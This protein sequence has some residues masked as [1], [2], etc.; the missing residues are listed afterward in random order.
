MPRLRTITLSDPKTRLFWGY[1]EQTQ[2]EYPPPCSLLSFRKSF[3]RRFIV[4]PYVGSLL[5]TGYG[6]YRLKA[7]PSVVLVEKG[8]KTF[9]KS[10]KPKDIFYDD[11]AEAFCESDIE[12]DGFLQEGIVSHLVLKEPERFLLRV[13]GGRWRYT[14]RELEFVKRLLP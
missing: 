13:G 2:A 4:Q 6:R 8:N 9:Y 14:Q 5:A 7:S 11:I 3:T 1:N 12:A 10:L